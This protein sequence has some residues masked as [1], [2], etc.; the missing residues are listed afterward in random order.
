MLLLV[1][2]CGGST[3]LDAANGQRAAQAE[4][5]G[6]SEE[7]AGSGAAG[8][9]GAQEQSA[10]G[11]ISLARLSK[12]MPIPGELACAG[13]GLVMI[14]SQLGAP[15]PSLVLSST[16]SE[17]TLATV[18]KVVHGE[19]GASVIC[20]V[21]ETEPGAFQISAELSVPAVHTALGEPVSPNA[22]VELIATVDAETAGNAAL[23]WVS[24]ADQASDQNCTLVVG[25]RDDGM[26]FIEPGMLKADFSCSSLANLD[27]Q[28]C[29][30]SGTLFLNHCGQ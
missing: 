29:E 23:T 27:L 24:Q 1:V 13:Q 3:E 25:T 9:S 22:L 16:T 7:D 8:S 5:D 12:L 4:E 17:A 26:P 14:P 30:A 2:G 11:A 21:S 19:D 18:A 20:S 6:G 28:T 15:N 10:E